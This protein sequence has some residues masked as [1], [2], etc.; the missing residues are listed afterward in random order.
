MTTLFNVCTIGNSSLKIITESRV[1]P[2]DIVGRMFLGGNLLFYFIDTN[3]MIRLRVNPEKS[4]SKQEL[5]SKSWWFISDN[6]IQDFV[7]NFDTALFDS[8]HNIVLT[9]SENSPLR[10]SDNSY[11]FEYFQ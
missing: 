5:K 1:R 10:L 4:P 3:T 11:R 6:V 7:Y 2:S 9:G 8:S